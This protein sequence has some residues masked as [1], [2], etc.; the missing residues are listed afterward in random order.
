[1]IEAR[2]RDVFTEAGAGTG[3]TGVLVERYCDAVSEDGVGPDRVLA[4]TFTER[5]AGELRERIRRRLTA[6]ARSALEQ[7]DPERSAEIARA[8]REGERA[9]ITTIHGFCR[10]LLATHPVAARM[11]PRFRVL[12]EAEAARLSERAFEVALE[13]TLEAG[14]GAIARFAAGFHPERLRAMVGAAYERL[15][16]QG[17][18]P[19]RLPEPGPASRS[20]KEK[21]ERPRAEPGGGEAGRGRPCG[22]ESAACRVQSS[23]RGVEGGALRRRLRRPRAAGARAVAGSRSGP[24]SLARPLRALDGGR[25]PGHQPRPAR[26]GRCSMRAADTA[27]HGGRRVPVHLPVPSRRPGG[28]PRASQQG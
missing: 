25:V 19:P 26:P 17:V 24:R 23:L 2:D 1:M 6:R 7:G 9:W 21:H 28:V 5:A 14:D 20:V 15:R 8:A 11:D 12:D 3:K 16:S 10:R 4:F 13:E 18:D 22:S 27:V